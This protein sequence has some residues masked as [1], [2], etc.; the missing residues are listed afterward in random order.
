MKEA[1]DR[2]LASLVVY[3]IIWIILSPDAY[4]EKSALKPKE[5]YD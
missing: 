3:G 2:A 5:G 4:A 1:G